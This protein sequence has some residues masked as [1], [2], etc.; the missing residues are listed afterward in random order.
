[1]V[2]TYI[3]LIISNVYLEPVV[4]PATPPAS[5]GSKAKPGT[6]TVKLS[7]DPLG[8]CPVDKMDMREYV[9]HV[10]L[11][12][13]PVLSAKFLVAAIVV[14]HCTTGENSHSL[15]GFFTMLLLLRTLAV[16]AFV[17][18][19]HILKSHDN[20]IVKKLG[21]GC[22]KSGELVG[23]FTK[24]PNETSVKYWLEEIGGYLELQLTSALYTMEKAETDPHM[25]KVVLSHLV[26]FFIMFKL[27]TIKFIF[28]ATL[29]I[30]L[31][32]PPVYSR[33]SNKI[34]PVIASA[35]DKAQ[36]HLEKL[37]GKANEGFNA[38][39]KKLEDAKKG[40]TEQV[41][42]TK[43]Q[44]AAKVNKMRHPVAEGAGGEGVNTKKVN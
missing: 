4:V 30:G 33:F 28:F 38:V 40:A 11:W 26:V 32:V 41:E 7:K 10:A 24:L 23:N 27:F 29:F 43:Q 8:A 16:F 20:T 42:K 13:N 39:A 15:A 35:Y 21:E 5:T 44:V 2:I 17:S 6:G 12:E 25:L 22:E 18:L 14:A 9:R 37:K 3:C 1:M 19:G 31:T 36:P 34:D